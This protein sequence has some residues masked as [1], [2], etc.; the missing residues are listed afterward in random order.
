MALS[1]SPSI[2]TEGLILC[3]DAAN[4]KS[5]P[6]T[7]T[8]WSNLTGS[9]SGTL[10]NGVG[11][12]SSNGGLLTFDGTNDYVNVPGLFDF[13]TTNQ[14]T[15]S[16][17]CK[18]N[19]ALWDDVGQL[20]SKRDQFIIHPSLNSKDVIYYVRVSTPAWAQQTVVPNSITVFNNYAMTYNSGDFRIFLNG[21]QS[22]QQ[23]V[24]STLN[25]DTGDTTIGKDDGL[26]RYLNGDVSNVFIYNRA[27]SPQEILQNF[28][29]LRGR[30]GL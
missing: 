25:S 11:F 19:T 26:E 1:H 4:L 23:S 7:G 16:I 12:S 10:I 5:Y 17:W 24:V 30:F 29:A 6:G 21:S 8:N 14:L 20:V 28:N 9:T 18:S 3:L 27:L 22:G 2:V 15:V 13:S